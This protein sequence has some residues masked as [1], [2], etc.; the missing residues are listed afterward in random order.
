MPACNHATVPTVS[1]REHGLPAAPVGAA[2]AAGQRPSDRQRPCRPHDTARWPGASG[3]STQGRGCLVHAPCTLHGCG[4]SATT[5]RSSIRDSG[6]R[7]ATHAWVMRPCTSHLRCTTLGGTGGLTA[8]QMSRRSRTAVPSA[9]YTAYQLVRGLAEGKRHRAPLAR[10]MELGRAFCSRSR[11]RASSA[12]RG[13]TERNGDWPRH[14]RVLHRARPD[15]HT[16]RDRAAMA[17]TCA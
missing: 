14:V 5:S 9:L 3:P 7:G 8:L 17:L 4:A 1:Q 2:H 6:R 11:P 16:L 10:A 13:G 12:R 15:Q